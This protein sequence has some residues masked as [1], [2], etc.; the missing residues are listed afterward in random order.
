[1]PT[2]DPI[3]ADELE[4]N[5]GPVPFVTNLKRIIQR[6]LPGI[7]DAPYFIVV[8]EQ[9]GIL[10]VAPQSLSHCLQNMWLKATSL[11]IGMRLVSVTMQMENDPDFCDLLGIPYG[12]YALDGCVLGYPSDNFQ[13]MPV[14]YPT[15]AQS[16]N[17]L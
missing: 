15:L 14:E 10:P 1:M 16:V 11:R 8:A 4:K 7:S 6:G 9:K 2:D 3:M 17:W 5:L 13:P 12:K